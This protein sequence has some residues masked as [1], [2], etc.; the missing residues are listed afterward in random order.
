MNYSFID[1][2]LAIQAVAYKVD[3][4]DLGINGVKYV[5]PKMMLHYAP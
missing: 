4:T 1:E 2:R 5:K 3:Y